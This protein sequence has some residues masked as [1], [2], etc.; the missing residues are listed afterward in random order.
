EQVIHA[1]PLK[2]HV[3]FGEGV[4]WGPSVDGVTIPDQ[5]AAL[6]A[7]GASAT[8]PVI[9]GSNADEGTLFFT[10]DGIVNS[11]AEFR[12]I[13]TELFNASEIDAIVA[14]YPVG[15]NPQATGIRV[16]SDIFTCGAR[17]IAQLHTAAGGVTYHYHF[18]HALYDV[19]I[20]LGALH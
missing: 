19:F 10:K 20:G 5:P 15:S 9:V 4:D 2:E 7:G 8:V 6:L 16:L 3:I 13:L 17:R 14:R 12:T 11:E 18:T 1:L